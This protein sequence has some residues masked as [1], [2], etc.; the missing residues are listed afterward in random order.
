M[1]YSRRV[2]IL[3]LWSHGLAWKMVW[4]FLYFFPNF[5]FRINQ[6]TFFCQ[7]NSKL[8]SMSLIPFSPLNV[9]RLS[10]N[11]Y[12]PYQLLLHIRRPAVSTLMSCF[13]LESSLGI[14][15][16]MLWMGSIW[17]ALA[18]TEALTRWSCCNVIKDWDLI[19]HK[20][21]CI[22]MFVLETIKDMDKI[23]LITNFIK[24]CATQ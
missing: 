21:S 2:A 13:W 17:N 12:P 15:L 6:P 23:D 16:L 18:L 4:S 20:H 11:S 3:Q 19:Y 8:V 7:T 24:L 14:Y 22:L 1:W 5:P 9:F 10:P